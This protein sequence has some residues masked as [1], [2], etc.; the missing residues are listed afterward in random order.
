MTSDQVFQ[1][2]LSPCYIPASAERS[3]DKSLR[4]N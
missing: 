3:L 4:Q 1:L 2:T